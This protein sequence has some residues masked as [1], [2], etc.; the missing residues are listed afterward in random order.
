MSYDAPR[1]APL[2]PAEWPREMRSALA[3]LA[4]PTKPPPT[5]TGRSRPKG[6]NVLGTFA[7]H[8]DLTA[9]FMTFNAHVLLASTLTARQRELVILR[10][11]ALRDAAYEWAQHVVLAQDSGIDQAEVARVADG[12]DAPGW[13]SFEQALLRAV[14][15][16]VT[17]A[18]ISDGT[19]TVLADTFD[20]RQVLDLVFTVG[21]YDVLAMALNTCGTPLDDDLRP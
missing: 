10:V 15:E 4:P 9:A 8:P 16:L 7:H 19:W 1:I 14:D 2:P 6:L 21:A 20:T 18:S 12:P 17:G 11:A 3:P 13:S 5:P